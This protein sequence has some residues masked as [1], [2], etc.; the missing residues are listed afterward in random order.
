MQRATKRTAS[1][2]APLAMYQITVA[3]LI[4]PI[5]SLMSFT[6][7]VVA[8]LFAM[9]RSDDGPGLPSGDYSA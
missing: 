4:I 9:A 5:F 2:S 8:L 1:S 6:P 3:K 7:I